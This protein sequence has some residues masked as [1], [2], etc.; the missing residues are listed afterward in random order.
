MRPGR[1]I[2][3]ASQVHPHAGGAR[4]PIGCRTHCE[5]IAIF[6]QIFGRSR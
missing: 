1:S 5:S 4:V 2:D 3:F 6:N